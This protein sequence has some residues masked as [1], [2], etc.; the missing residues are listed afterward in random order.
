MLELRKQY[1]KITIN[2]VEKNIPEYLKGKQFYT[3]EE[4][5]ELK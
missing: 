2:D 4:Y 5:A 1:A 3:R